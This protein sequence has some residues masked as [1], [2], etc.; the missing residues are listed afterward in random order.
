LRLACIDI[1]SNT[2][3]LLVAEPDGNGGLREIAAGR[4]LNRLGAGRSADGALAPERVA[5]AGAEVA[6]LVA[7]A[8]EHGAERVLAVATAAVRE[9]PDPAAVCAELGRAGEIEVVLL[10]GDAEARFAFAGATCAV[11]PRPDGAIAVVDVGGGSTEIIVG[12]CTGGPVWSTS[13]ALGSGSLTEAELHADPPTAAQ[14]D[15]ARARAVAALAAVDPPAAHAA[16]AVGGSATSLARVLGGGDLSRPA[17]ARALDA[18]CAEPAA[19]LAARHGLHVE[20]MRML[21][22][23]MAILDATSERLGVDLQ[24][25]DAGLRE[26]VILAMLNGDV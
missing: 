11:K 5:R 18:L 8:R 16:W 13:I 23:G 6:A 2:T 14:L 1:G 9:A 17:L 22:A 26:G 20:R 24:M 15:G 12:T 21:P 25:A 10:D 4:A 19:V 7:A 3:R